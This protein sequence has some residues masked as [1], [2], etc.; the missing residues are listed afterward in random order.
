[1]VIIS[2]CFRLYENCLVNDVK[3]RR[4]VNKENSEKCKK[5]LDNAEKKRKKKRAN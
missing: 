1:M 5:K 3:G 2:F 4:D